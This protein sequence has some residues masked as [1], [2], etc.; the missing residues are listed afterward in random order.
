MYDYRHQVLQLYHNQLFV[1]NN[2][3]SEQK[4]LIEQKDKQIGILL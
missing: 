2:P 4:Y 3:H 1:E